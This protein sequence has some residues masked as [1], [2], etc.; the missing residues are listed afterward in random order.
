LRYDDKVR[1]AHDN[2]AGGEMMSR[3][4][5][6]R[7]I[8]AS[9]ALSALAFGSF[10]CQPTHPSAE[11]QAK[12]AIAN[13]RALEPL[14]QAVDTCIHA[15]KNA[16]SEQA[17]KSALETLLPGSKDVFEGAKITNDAFTVEYEA[18]SGQSLNATFDFGRVVFAILGHIHGFELFGLVG[19]PAIYCTEA[20]FWYDGQLG[21]QMGSLL[22]SRLRLA[23]PQV[24][25]ELVTRSPPGGGYTVALPASW[26]FRN[27][28]YPS[29][30]ATHLW[31]DPAHPL[32][33][34]QGRPQRVHRVR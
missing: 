34:M 10:G 27:A 32:E 11:A 1:Y 33:K 25:G 21:G 17:I 22:R 31:Y 5:K 12:A 20:A 16:A 6:A 15:I 14:R 9:A 3:T 7:F 8:A 30:H 28:S 29:D 24:V 13:I 18:S 23:P 4:L 2:S 26:Q 19:D